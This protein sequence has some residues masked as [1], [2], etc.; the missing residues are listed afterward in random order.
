M[1]LHPQTTFIFQLRIQYIRMERKLLLDGPKVTY[2]LVST[3]STSFLFLLN[4]KSYSNVSVFSN[5]YSILMVYCIFIFYY[6][7]VNKVI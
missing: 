1:H 4:S 2:L 6:L 5:T 3:I 7:N